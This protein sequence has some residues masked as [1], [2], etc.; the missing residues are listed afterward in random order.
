MR[1]VVQRVSRASVSV[2]GR[3]AGSYSSLFGWNLWERM[4]VT[5]DEQLV[6]LTGR[7]GLIEFRSEEA[8]RL[9]LVAQLSLGDAVA[10]GSG[11]DLGAEAVEHAGEPFLGAPA[12]VPLVDLAARLLEEEGVRFRNLTVKS[13]T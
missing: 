2:G 7:L 5:I 9:A 11:R 3:A 6:A 4:T 8:V 1:I 12:R 13:A 10:L